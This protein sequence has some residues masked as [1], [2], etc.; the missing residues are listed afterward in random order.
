[1]LDFPRGNIKYSR[2]ERS[3]GRAEKWDTPSRQYFVLPH[4]VYPKCA[5][6]SLEHLSCSRVR[7]YI[8]SQATLRDG[9]AATLSWYPFVVRPPI[10]VC[11][12][13][14]FDR[15]GPSN[16]KGGSHECESVPCSTFVRILPSVVVATPVQPALR[17]H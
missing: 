17:V 9:H 7:R 5:V 2:I 3:R 11:S 10:I 14:Y 13:L 6:A 15:S 16:R 1:M 8:V 4:G 12:K